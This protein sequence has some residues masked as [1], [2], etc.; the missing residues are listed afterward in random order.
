METFQLP[1]DLTRKS[2]AIWK[3]L[4][5]KYCISEESNKDI[6]NT[7]LIVELESTKYVKIIEGEE[8]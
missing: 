4:A 8:N 1:K 2:L 5:S 6:F 7:P 3:E